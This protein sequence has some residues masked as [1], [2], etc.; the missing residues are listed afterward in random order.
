MP[1]SEDFISPLESI[2]PS[3]HPY[4]PPIQQ[5]CMQAARTG[6]ANGLPVLVQQV[7][8]GHVYGPEVHDS[9][10]ESGNAQ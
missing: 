8:C 7:F 2:E 3:R 1:A 6:D 10:K 9:P 5:A 4:I